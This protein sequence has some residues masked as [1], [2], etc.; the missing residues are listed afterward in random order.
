M[1]WYRAK[2]SEKIWSRLCDW[3]DKEQ[4]E[5]SKDDQAKW[6]HTEVR[7]HECVVWANGHHSSMFLS[8]AQQQCTVVQKRCGLLQVVA[9]GH[10]GPCEECVHC[11]HILVFL[12]FASRLGKEPGEA[13]REDG[14]MSQSNLMHGGWVLD[15]EPGDWVSYLAF[16]FQ[17]ADL[18]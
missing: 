6:A 5:G 17:I 7:S 9:A 12:I 14:I 11:G 1:R 13:E 16:T 10:V 15:S 18:G 4:K 8:N 3:P 2:A